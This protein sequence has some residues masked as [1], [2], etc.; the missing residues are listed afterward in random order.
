MSKKVKTIKKLIIKRITLDPLYKSYWYSK[1]VNKL[2]LN[3]KK[4]VIEKVLVKVWYSFKLKNEARPIEILFSSLIRLKPLVGIIKKR[5]GKGWKEIPFPLEPRRQLVISLKWLI[6]QIRM[7][8]EITLYARTLRTLS[9]LFN[10]K[11]KKKRNRTSD[12]LRKK[13]SH[14]YSIIKDRVNTRFRWR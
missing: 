1:F 12:V 7:D 9:G 10:K 5:R 2:M 6:S 8:P 13:K 3:G 11:L 14:Y 4:H